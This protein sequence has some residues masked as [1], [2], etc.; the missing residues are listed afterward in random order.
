[1]LHNFEFK[2]L[3]PQC[4]IILKSCHNVIIEINLLMPLRDHIDKGESLSP[5][6]LLKI[7][8]SGNDLYMPSIYE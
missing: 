7:R 8:A 6:H 2:L 4:D 5:S 3:M 1:M